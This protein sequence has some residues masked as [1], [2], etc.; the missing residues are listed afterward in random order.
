MEN[1]SKI[2]VQG[3]EGTFLKPSSKHEKYELRPYDGRRI[4]I[5]DDL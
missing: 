2:K 4:M 1:S 3:R 5:E